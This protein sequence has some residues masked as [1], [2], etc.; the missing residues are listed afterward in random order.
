MWFLLFFAIAMVFGIMQIV[1]TS[2]LKKAMESHLDSVPDFTPTQKIMG[3]DGNSGLSF[4]ES[5]KKICV[6]INRGG[7][8]SQRII[9][10]KD[11][12]SVEIF[13]DGSSVTKTVRSSQIG[14]AVIGGLV[15]GGV[16]AIIGGLSGK[17]ETSGKIKRVD[18]R[19][20]LNDTNSPLHD[21]VLMNI[22]AKKESI[23]YTHAI[24]QARFWHG[25]IE[26]LI[27]R[28]DAEDRSLQLEGRPAAVAASTLSI[29]DE[30]KKLSE[31]HQA[32]VLTAEEFQQQ[33]NK[34]LNSVVA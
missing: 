26:V 3:C 24:Q 27:K 30:I 5:R 11:I 19:L 13:E 10:Y 8:I 22:E 18:L 12:I 21:V 16:G 14:G 2:K 34:L 6:I 17:T 4:D 23:I 9:E 1:G 32:G 7:Y 25:L 29:A 33:K 20:I 31:L 28:A 15:L